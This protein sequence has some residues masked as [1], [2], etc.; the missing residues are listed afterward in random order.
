MK[1]KI[2][3]GIY[4]VLDPSINKTELLERL[5]QALDGGVDTVQIWNH[6]PGSI[7]DSDKVDLIEKI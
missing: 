1:K 6:W 4:L 7:S 2:T 5:K 3:G